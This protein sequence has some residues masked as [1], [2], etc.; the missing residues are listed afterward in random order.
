[1]KNKTL[2]IIKEIL[3]DLEKILICKLKEVLKKAGQPVTDE[4]ARNILG[5][6]GAR[7]VLGEKIYETNK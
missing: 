7:I 4:V 2:E 3:D 1:M 5:K 6:I